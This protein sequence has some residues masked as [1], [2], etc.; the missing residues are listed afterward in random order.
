MLNKHLDHRIATKRRNII[1]SLGLFLYCPGLWFG[2]AWFL[3]RSLSKHFEG[4][5]EGLDGKRI[6]SMS[7]CSQRNDATF[8][9]CLG[10]PSES[11]HFSWCGCFYPESISFHCFFCWFHFLGYVLKFKEL[12]VTLFKNLFAKWNSILK[13]EYWKKCAIKYIIISQ[14]HRT[15]NSFALELVSSGCNFGTKMKATPIS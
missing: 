6:S 7:T 11:S 9:L 4:N 12:L 8:S 13:S 3:R 14:K 5:N 15:C 2:I 10:F 1:S